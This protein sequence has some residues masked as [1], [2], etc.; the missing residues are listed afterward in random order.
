M[1]RIGWREEKPQ[2][3]DVKVPVL[4]ALKSFAHRVGFV[5]FVRQVMA[6]PFQVVSK[7]SELSWIL[8]LWVGL[9]RVQE[10][11]FPLDGQFCFSF[12][13][14]A[15]LQVVPVSRLV[16]GVGEGHC[17]AGCSCCSRVAAGSL[18]RCHYHATALACLPWLF[19]HEGRILQTQTG[20]CYSS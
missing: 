11:G 20:V 15:M 7:T 8:C 18:L 13:S 5:L 17:G 19:S 2:P 4:A 9:C 12:T 3:G 10:R 6:K 16:W 1:E 14:P